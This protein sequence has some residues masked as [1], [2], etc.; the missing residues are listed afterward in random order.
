MPPAVSDSLDLFN[1]SRADCQNDCL[2]MVDDGGATMASEEMMD[3]PPA[4]CDV[5]EYKYAYH[6]CV[7]RI[8]AT[9]LACTNGDLTSCVD[10]DIYDTID[11]L[12]Y[13]EDGQVFAYICNDDLSMSSG[14]ATSCDATTLTT[15]DETIPF[16]WG[17]SV[18]VG[19]DDRRR[20]LGE[21]MPFPKKKG[22]KK[23]HP[24]HK[25]KVT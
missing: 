22:A 24:S 5:D 9:S 13:E 3:L 15:V 11:E 10:Y 21:K 14:P 1:A 12:C 20:R 16:G 25:K 6:F 2:C 17:L 8:F 4:C 18:V 7:G 19:C 23:H